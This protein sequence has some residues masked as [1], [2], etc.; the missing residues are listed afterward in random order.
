MAIHCSQ[1]KIISGRLGH[2]LPPELWGGRE[3]V[4]D[5]LRNSS[6]L[7]AWTGHTTCN[8]T[9]AQIHSALHLRQLITQPYQ[10]PWRWA[11]S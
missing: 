10:A 2:A 11:S 3:S 8:Q 9:N 5:K 6:T 7:L 1:T 4:V